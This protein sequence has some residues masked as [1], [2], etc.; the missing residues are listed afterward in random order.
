PN[1]GFE[2]E[3][4]LSYQSCDPNGACDTAEVIISVVSPIFATNDPPS[5]IDDAEFMGVNTPVL[6]SVAN[7]DSDPNAGDNLSW[8]LLDGP[9]NGSVVLNPDGSYTYTPNGGYVG[10]DFFTYAVCDDGSPVLC[11]SATAYITINACGAS[12][13]HLSGPVLSDN[14]VGPNQSVTLTATPVGDAVVPNAYQILYVLTSGPALIIEQV[15]STPSFMVNMSGSYTLHTL[16]YNPATLDLSGVVFG[17][18][19]ASV[20]AAQLIENGGTIC[21]SLDVQGVSAHLNA[22]SSIGDLVWEDTNGNGILEG[23]E[24]GVD[25]ILITLLECINGTKTNTVVST[26]TT[27]NGGFYTFTDLDPSAEYYLRIEGTNLP[28]GYLF[29]P[30]NQG[31]NPALDSDFDPLSGETDCIAFVPGQTI[32]DI[33]AGILL[34]KGTLGGD[35]FDDLNQNGIQDL[36][37]PG[38]DGISVNLLDCAGNVLTSTSTA[39]GGIYAF[40]NL[41][42]NIDYVLEFSDL[43]SNFFFSLQDQGGDDDL[44]SDVNLAGRTIC[45][46]LAPGQTDLSWDAGI[47]LNPCATLTCPGLIGYNEVDC[48]PF[49][50]MP[51]VE[52][53][54]ACTTTNVALSYVWLQTTDPNLPAPQWTTVVGVNG[55]TYDPPMITETTYYI[56]CVVA[57]GCTTYLE[58]NVIRKEINP[59]AESTCTLDDNSLNLA[60]EVNGLGITGLSNTYQFVNEGKLTVKDDGTAQIEGLIVNTSNPNAVW[61]LELDLKE[62]RDYM[63]WSNLM[64]TNNSGHRTYRSGSNGLD[65]NHPTWDYY[66]IDQASSRLVG[67]GMF[68]GQKIYLD[69]APANFVH[70]IQLGEGANGLDTGYGIGGAFSFSGA[71]TGTGSFTLGVANCVDVCPKKNRLVTKVMMEGAFDQA[72]GEMEASLANQNLIPLNQ[73]YNAAPWNYSGTESLSAIPTQMIDWILLELRSAADSTQI[74]ARQAVWLDKAGYLH[75]VNANG[76]YPELEIDPAIDQ[77]FLVVH[78]RNHLGLMSANS[79][80]LIGQSFLIDLSSDPSK[81]LTNPQFNDAGYVEITPGVYGL[82]SGDISGNGYINATDLQQAIIQYFNGGYLSP[83]PT[84]NGLINATDLQQVINNYFKR[85]HVTPSN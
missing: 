6:A 2:G 79:L 18:T 67:Y 38:V 68:T 72:T 74:L 52:L 58:S 33:D 19:P 35:V 63:E 61:S 64:T 69:H 22:C 84:L 73:P 31:G 46:D 85:S 8:S 81:I 80:D 49:D 53:V 3:E 70:A 23:G 4:V 1:P 28:A 62:R 25:G 59:N 75:E 45:I 60:F 36:N 10:G 48:G 43:P 7:N 16:V 14:C 26:T 76:G 34:F 32:D 39:N 21:A 11:D 54:P 9:A 42:P 15:S 65:G 55:P 30:A 50:P 47:F 37:E 5:A 57:Q 24:S 66:E 20:I 77:V 29:S 40:S 27:A 13:G 56:R 12:A 71:Y 41:S 82:I 51:I 44:D 83:D 17:S 78:H